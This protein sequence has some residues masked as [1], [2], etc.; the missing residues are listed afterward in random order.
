MHSREEIL[1]MRER[2]NPKHF[3]VRPPDP[4]E[5]NVCCVLSLSELQ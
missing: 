3:V 5:G 2:V 4:E 1:A